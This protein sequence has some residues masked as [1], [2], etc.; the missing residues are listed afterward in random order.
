MH[1]TA[2]TLLVTGIVALIWGLAKGDSGQELAMRLVVVPL[3][4]LG[5]KTTFDWLRGA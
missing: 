1:P 4:S 3:L 5:L 2:Q